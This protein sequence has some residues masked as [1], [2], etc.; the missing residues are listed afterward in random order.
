MHQV[1][2]PVELVDLVALV[3]QQVLGGVRIVL[4]AGRPGLLGDPGSDLSQTLSSLF[5]G[6]RMISTT[7]PTKAYVRAFANSTK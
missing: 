7:M 6:R 3:V 2:H 1:A 5:V 4:A